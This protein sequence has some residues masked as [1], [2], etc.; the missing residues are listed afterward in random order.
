MQT[1]VGSSLP[2][3]AIVLVSVFGTLF[4]RWILAKN[5]AVDDPRVAVL[6]PLRVDRLLGL[7]DVLLV[8][9]PFLLDRFRDLGQV[10]PVPDLA[11]G[12]FD[13]VR[14]WAVFARTVLFLSGLFFD[15]IGLILTFGQI[16]LPQVER[17]FDGAQHLERLVVRVAGLFS[18][19]LL[20][21]H[22]VVLRNEDGHVEQLLT[23]RPLLRV[24]LQ[25]LAQ[26]GR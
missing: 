22:L 2:Q 21:H 23:S 12:D 3:L 25:E 7:T 17:H 15:H 16:K 5:V 14:I 8:D 19:L 20:Q 10:R 9:W 6:A 13:F 18:L 1:V 11:A 4:L 26:D 24:N